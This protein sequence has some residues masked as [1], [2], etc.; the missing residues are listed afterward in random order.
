V[1]ANERDR[2]RIVLREPDERPPFAGNFSVN[3]PIDSANGHSIGCSRPQPPTPK[4][5][6]VATF[7]DGGG[8]MRQMVAWIEALR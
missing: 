4:I 6:Y 1:S 3:R 8:R 2:K 5:I 7:I